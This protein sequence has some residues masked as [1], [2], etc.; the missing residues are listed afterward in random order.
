[1]TPA[2]D[3]VPLA[4]RRPRETSFETLNLAPC[5]D[6]QFG[7][8]QECQ[9]CKPAWGCRDNLELGWGTNTALEP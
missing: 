6:G 1:M 7:S 9:A 3:Q 5:Y 4:D 8:G 2:A